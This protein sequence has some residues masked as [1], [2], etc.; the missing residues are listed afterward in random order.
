ME[1]EKE[2]LII[3]DLLTIDESDKIESS[4]LGPWFP[5]Y[6][7]RGVDYDND[8]KFQF[9]HNF[10]KDGDWVS[11][12]KDVINPILEKL[13]P[14]MLIKIKANLTMRSTAE[15]TFRYHI[16]VDNKKS[17]TAIYY[18]N[19]SDGKTVIKDIETIDCKKNRLVI[20]PSELFHAGVMHSTD[21]FG[22]KCIINFNF[23]PTLT[24]T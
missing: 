15:S 9:V 3:D 6:L 13:N 16:D 11:Y 14:H 8:G 23:I 19:D 2:I 10:Y 21:I 5:W 24:K 7:W 22:G 12:E 17:K 18:V 1:N 4:L 20:F